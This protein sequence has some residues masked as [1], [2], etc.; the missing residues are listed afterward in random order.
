MLKPM[1]SPSTIRFGD[2]S[3]TIVRIDEMK[4]E[5]L[6]ANQQP[7]TSADKPQNR[8]L[9]SMPTCTVMVRFIVNDDWNSRIDWEEMINYRSCINKSTA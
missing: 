6:K 1:N 5:T 9:T 3:A 4:R 7:I 2:A 8:T